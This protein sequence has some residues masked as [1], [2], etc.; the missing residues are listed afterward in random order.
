[1]IV[2]YHYVTVNMGEYVKPHVYVHV[3]YSGDVILK[4]EYVEDVPWA[5]DRVVTSVIASAYA[6][7]DNMDLEIVPLDPFTADK[8]GK[9]FCRVYVWTGPT[10][11]P[12]YVKQHMY[13]ADY[14]ERIDPWQSP[15]SNPD[16]PEVTY[17]E[18]TQPTGSLSKTVWEQWGREVSEIEAGQ[19]AEVTVYVNVKNFAGGTVTLEVREDIPWGFDKQLMTSSKT[20]SQDGTITISCVFSVPVE[21]SGIRGVFVKVYGTVNGQYVAIY[22]ETDPNKRFSDGTEVKVVFPSA[23]TP[24][25]PT[26]TPPPG[27]QPY[28]H[29]EDVDWRQGGSIVKYIYAGQSAEVY[30][31][32]TVANF[33][34]GTITM[35]VREDVPYWFDK[36][37]TTS[38]VAVSKDGVVRITAVFTVPMTDTSARGVFIKLYG[39][40][41]GQSVI[42]YDETNPNQRFEDGT[43]V[44]GRY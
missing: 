39:N 16:R 21:D 44:R 36:L 5:P 37:L 13:V 2:L 14:W 38:N 43:E 3:L 41:N 23:P 18:S 7:S 25:S 35:E 33:V 12:E 9:Y 22:D 32:V 1:L 29:L 17:V 30:A 8:P 4:I 10:D 27:G 26:P 42:I 24:P 34:G 20:V 40:V 6:P 11:E 15:I 19:L 31:Y 28:A